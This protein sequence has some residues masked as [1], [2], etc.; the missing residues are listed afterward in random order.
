MES[1]VELSSPFPVRL[2]LNVVEDLK[3]VASKEQ[4]SFSQ[5]LRFRVLDSWSRLP[6]EE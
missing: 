6:K 4:R 1:K 3:K 2:P 5:E